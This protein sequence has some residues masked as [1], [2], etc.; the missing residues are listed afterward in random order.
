[1]DSNLG[2]HYGGSSMKIA[3]VRDENRSIIVNETGDR[4]TPSIFAIN[5]SEI[6]IGL[7]AKQNM[8]RNAKNTMLHSKHLFANDL[9]KVD[10]NILK[11]NQSEIKINEHEEI[12]FSVEKDGEPIDLTLS[13]VVEKQLTFLYDLAKSSL[14]VKQ[15]DA[16]LSVP[17][18]FTTQET[19]FLKKRAENTGFHVLRMIKNPIA[20]CLAYD[21]EEDVSVANLSLV[22]QIGGNSVEVSLVNVNN[23]LYRILDTKAVKNIGGDKFTD[24]IVDLCIDEFNRK[25]RSTPFSKN[26]KR[27]LS[28]LK[29]SA[30]D[31]K[32]ILSTMERA[33]AS[34]DALYEG[35]DFDYY[36]P[37]QRFEGVC[38]RLY[39]QVLAPI[40]EILEANNIEHNRVNQVI[41]VGAPSKMCRLQTLIKQKFN[42]SKI[43][44]TQSPD[45]IIALGC[46]KQCSLISNS[47]HMKEIQNTDL[48]FKCTSK[49][50]FLKVGNSP[51][52][53]SVCKANAPFP[54]KR[55]LSLQLDLA[56]P[57]LTLLES[58]ERL[59]AKIDLKEFKTKEIVFN[60]NIKMN[61]LIE[62]SVTETSSKKKL[63][64]FL[65]ENSLDVS[66]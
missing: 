18:Y 35:I 6:S 62:V 45:E 8:I 34:I 9:S 55:T 26:N 64:A 33:H 41:M 46:A 66:N 47:K 50:I 56:E 13:E 40:D 59:L 11:K 14:N 52:Y 30:E 21:I 5:D 29:S 27:S 24:L 43:L 54:I 37:R 19:E 49:P 63:S 53:L 42:G 12:V 60:F 10:E 31:L 4:S 22:Y 17:C 36:L 61:G 25:N 16:V 20:A 39:E 3:F 57:V 23:G 32:H 15:H 7:P 65:N 51:D 58:N 2:V 38:G 28:K 48:I 44:N 1:M